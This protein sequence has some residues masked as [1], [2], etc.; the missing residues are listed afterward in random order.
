MTLRAA[1]VETFRSESAAADGTSV[2]LVDDRAENLVALRAVLEPLS[3]DLNFVL[4]EA[5]SADEALRHVLQIGDGLALVLLDVRMPGTDGLETARLIRQRS[6][7]EH[8]PIIFVT[9]VETNRR[10]VTIGYQSGAVDYLMKPLDPD[11]VRGKV[12]SF[13]TIHRRRHAADVR[14]RRRFADQAAAA[15]AEA[16]E[17]LR[18]SDARIRTVLD[19]LPDAVSI[20]DRDW[21]FTYV[22][23]AG[24]RVLARLGARTRDLIGKVLWDVVP[25][26]PGSPFERQTRAAAAERREVVYETYVPAL[27]AWVEERAGPGPDGSLTTYGR[28]I[29]DRRRAEVDR[30][31]AHAEADLARAAAEQAREAAEAAN[32]AKG[33]FLATMS[34]EFRTPLNAQLGYL[35]L[36]E[37]GIAGPMS[38]TQQQYLRRLRASSDHLLGLVNDVLDLAKVEA[39]QLTVEQ[40]VAF[41][42]RAVEGAVALVLPQAEAKGVAMVDKGAGAPCVSYL[43]DTHR[44]R[45]ILLNLLSNAVKFTAPGGSVE[46]ACSASLDG[47]PPAADGER[48]GGDTDG[49]A[50]WAAISVRDTGIG[51]APRDLE[52]VFAPFHQVDGGHT[53]AEGGTGLGLAISRRLARLMG[54]DLMVES[55]AGQGSTFTLWLPGPPV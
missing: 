17:A 35:Q 5:R 8:V 54:G 28:D 19:A 27:D 2:L 21:R 36:L 38:E 50:S 34:H 11:V 55:S 37:L 15:K 25:S 20:F 43:G 40:A 39:G 51:I 26:V 52:S 29:T 31:H 41:A 32:R 24:R 6:H 7:S 22:N 1:H 3:E 12:R 9:G 53:R 45:Q 49:V 48:E 16:A 44:V 46:I 47:P 10:G 33:I 23:P 42:E 30:E 4:H 18:A 13:V 14:E